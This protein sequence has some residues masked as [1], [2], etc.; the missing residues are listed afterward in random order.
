MN[1]DLTIENPW[2]SEE[3]RRARETRFRRLAGGTGPIAD[4]AADVL[5][6]R[7]EPHELLTHGPAAEEIHKQFRAGTKLWDRLAGAERARITERAPEIIRGMVAEH[8]GESVEAPAEQPRARRRPRPPEDEF[9]EDEA[10][11]RSFL[12][13]RRRES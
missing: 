6:G 12:L 13:G 7:R 1:P 10:F 9:D 4:F 3:G 8:A 11:N 2:D 5:A